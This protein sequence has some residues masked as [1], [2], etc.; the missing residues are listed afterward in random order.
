MA[1]FAFGAFLLG[2]LSHLFADMLSAPDIAQPIEPF[3]PF[4]TKP[5]SV[6][7]LWYN[8]PWWN[9]GLLAVAVLLHVAVAYAVEPFQHSYRIERT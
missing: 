3:W 6:D 5:W 8:S 1:V 2:G 4:L 9:A 7:L